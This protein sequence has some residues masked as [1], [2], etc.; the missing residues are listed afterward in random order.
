MSMIEC[1]KPKR[2][3]YSIDISFII[4][5][6]KRVQ[7]SPQHLQYITKKFTCKV[8]ILFSA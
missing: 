1:E 7:T 3:I 6:K 8:P 5:T 2:V 4:K